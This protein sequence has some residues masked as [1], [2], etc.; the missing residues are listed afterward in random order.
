[1]IN[2]ISRTDNGS[3]YLVFILSIIHFLLGLD[4]NIVSISLPSIA[5]FFHTTPNNISAIVWVYFLIVTCFLLFFGKF[6]D[7]FG[8]RKIFLSGVAVFT[9]GSL[10]SALSP[11][12]ILLISSRVVQ[13]LG[14]A[15]LFALTP[16]IISAHIP[17]K[18]R[19]RAYGINY[20][21]VAI[22]GVIGR[23]ASGY[24]IENF[25]WQYIFLINIPVGIFALYMAYK[26]IPDEKPEN[27]G[28]PFDYTGTLLIFI[29][30]LSLLFAI[31]KVNEFGF[32]SPVILISIAVFI[33]F[34]FLFIRRQRRFSNPLFQL[35]LL[36][37]KNLSIHFLLFVVIYIIT[38][39]TI[40]L[41]PFFLG[42]MK[43][44]GAKEIG[45][46][47]TV[48]SLMQ[49]FSGYISGK[50]S[51]YI[52]SKKIMSAGLII[53]FVSYIF[54]LFLGAE[55]SFAF[56]IIVMAVYGFAIGFSIPVNTNAVMAYSSTYNKGSLSSFMTTLVRTGSA[57][58][59]CLYAAINNFFTPQTSATNMIQAYRY[60]FIFGVI[61]IFTGLVLLMLLDDNEQNP[62]EE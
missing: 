26:L 56:I 60:T 15:V 40:F 11:N 36:K 44:Y 52:S 8:F 12:V 3:N 4:I 20:S 46:M 49:M 33:V 2:K 61:V 39:G 35:T 57:L 7:E 6:G 22:G 50:L 58:G 47:M 55:S 10:L 43:I 24:L 13:A 29:T 59:V 34:G 51:D 62:D 17:E 23:S 18:V 19:G 45:L 28:K 5:T 21:F 27:I 25:G 42:S 48:P 31:N 37:N 30:L 54:N 16:A 9:I 32:T 1:M 41:F 38:N 53:L 14:A